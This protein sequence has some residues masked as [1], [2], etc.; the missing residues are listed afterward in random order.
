MTVST[1]HIPSPRA[2]AQ[3]GLSGGPD[4]SVVIVT[5][6]AAGLIGDCLESLRRE[7][8]DISAEIFVV[9]SNSTDRTVPLIQA[10]FP[11]VRLH[12]AGANLGFS[13]GNNLALPHCRGRYVVLLNPDTLVHPGALRD[14]AAYLDR[15]S[16]V[17]AVGPTLRLADGTI[18]PECARYLPNL[19]NMLPWLLMLDKLQWRL[20]HG[21][22]TR[23]SE[24]VPPRPGLLDGFNLLGWARDRTCP[25]ESLCGACMMIRREVVEQIGLLDEDSPLYLDDIDYC[26][27]ILD[28]GW[29]L[30][31]V[32]GPTVTHLW[33]QSTSQR[34]RA[35]DRYAM[36]CQAIW[37]Y[38][39]KHEGP[40]AARVFA[41]MT[42]LTAIFRILVCLPGSLLP[43]RLHA[44]EWRRRLE[45]GL[46]L[47]R[48]A[49][50]RRPRDFGFARDP[51]A[52]AANPVAGS[53]L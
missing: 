42:L 18:Q 45:M 49:L 2:A 21:R 24:T 34:N 44:Q 5:Y 6:N 23:A 19:G 41:A 28:A 20:R 52:R 1:R 26:R 39:R 27:R 31:Y 47:G 33:E 10:Q 51:T 48:W 36:Q 29:P 12:A 9:D 22:R 4:L 46:M 14:L 17:G 7:C 37:F 50:R 13:A 15:H 53:H 25:I 16:Q 11:E 8:R 38:F 32:A 43:F 30:H 3:S 35:G 40:F